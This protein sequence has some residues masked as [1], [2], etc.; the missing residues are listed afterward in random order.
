[1]LSRSAILPL[2]TREL[3]WNQ[4]LVPPERAKTGGRRGNKE[5][6]LFF[7]RERRGVRDFAGEKEGDPQEP[8]ME[9]C[10]V[11][12]PRRNQTLI[13]RVQDTSPTKWEIIQK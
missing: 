3:S 6:M 8:E 12:A 10:L 11:W 4:G 1:M 5:K 2:S 13:P 7:R 9:C